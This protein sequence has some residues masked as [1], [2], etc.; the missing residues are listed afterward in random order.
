[1]PSLRSGSYGDF[2]VCEVVQLFN[3]IH[4]CCET[5]KGR[6]ARLNVN[7]VI[8]IQPQMIVF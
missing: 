1:V 7:D 3:M 6:D 8:P 4:V 5:S 2:Q